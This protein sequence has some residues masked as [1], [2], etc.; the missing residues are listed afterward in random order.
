MVPA[1]PDNGA[2]AELRDR[3]GQA[4]QALS[5]LVAEALPPRKRPRAHRHLKETLEFSGRFR[6]LASARMHSLRWAYT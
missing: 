3:P 6:L 1:I 2:L 4:E 5:T